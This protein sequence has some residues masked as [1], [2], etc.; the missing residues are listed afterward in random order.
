VGKQRL[1]AWRAISASCPKPYLGVGHAL[2]L[3]I[4]ALLALA[5]N[6]CVQQPSPRPRSWNEI[7]SDV[8]Q[9]VIAIDPEVV[10]LEFVASPTFQDPA[11]GSLQLLFHYIRPSGDIIQVKVENSLDGTVS[12]PEKWGHDRGWVALTAAEHQRW[13]ANSRSLVVGPDEVLQRVFSHVPD[14]ADALGSADILI[15]LDIDANTNER[16]QTP[17]VWRAHFFTD[18]EERVFFVNPVTGDILDDERRVEK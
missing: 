1:W 5:L 7:Y 9:R 11:D 10:L 17:A 12:M 13:I 18:A 8:Q 6:G 16:F 4:V 3:L 14:E 2:G 15:G